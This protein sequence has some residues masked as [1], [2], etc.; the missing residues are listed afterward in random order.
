[1]ITAILCFMNEHWKTFFQVLMCKKKI[2]QHHYC[3]IYKS[4]FVELMLWDITKLYVRYIV[5]V[6]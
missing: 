3:S 2:I 6:K 1:M 5:G 4:L